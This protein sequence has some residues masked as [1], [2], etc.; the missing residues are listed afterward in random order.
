[1]LSASL[2]KWEGRWERLVG[3]VKT[4]VGELIANEHFVQEGECEQRL[5]LLKESLGRSREE[6]EE[7]L[8]RRMHP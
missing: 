3:K 4:L 8:E 5:G 2:Q 1:M 7:T 6:F